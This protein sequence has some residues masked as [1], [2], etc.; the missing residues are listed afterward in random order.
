M[1]T[2]TRQRR[3]GTGVPSTSHI[4]PKRVRAT[5]T[6]VPPRRRRSSQQPRQQVPGTGRQQA[7]VQ[8]RRPASVPSGGH[9]PTGNYQPVILAEFVGC[10]LLTAATP[11]ARSSAQEGLSP[12]AGA[13]M[14]KLASITVLYLILAMVSV[15]GQRAARLAAWLGGLI[16]VADGLYEASNLARDLQ[17]FTGGLAGYASAGNTAGVAA[18]AATPALAPAPTGPTPPRPEPVSGSSIVISGGGVP[19]IRPAGG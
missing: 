15:S 10:V 16:L 5:V 14:V 7:A 12:Y 1:A 6:D 4:A 9:V 11:F 2:T 13:D 17:L 8:F 18:P 3:P 19:Q